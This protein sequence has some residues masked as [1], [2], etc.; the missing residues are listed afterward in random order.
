M[1][2]KDIYLDG[3]KI[4]EDSPTFLIAEVGVNHNGEIRIAKKLIDV[5]VKAQVDAVKF[6]TFITDKL[7]LK[8][9]PKVL[10]QKQSEGDKENFYEMIK[11]YEFTRDNF[12][13]LEEYCREKNIIFLS[14]PFDTIS[15]EWLEELNVPAFKVGSGDMNNYPL[16]KSIS[17]K[18]KPIL[19]STG[20]ATLIEVKE[21]VEFIKS[22]GNDSIVIF[23][24]TTNYPALD[25]ELNLNVLDTYKREFPDLF[26]GFS[27]HSVGLEASIG[28]VTKGAKFIEKHFTLDKSMVGPDHK[29]SL[30]P[31]E[32]VM[33]V[34]SIRKIE[35]ALG[36]YEKK[37]SVSEIEIAKIA[38]KSIV[39]KVDLKLGDIITENNI[40]TKR[41]GI[42][43][44]ASQYYKI[45]GKKVKTKAILKDTIIQMEDL[46]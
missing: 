3:R 4:S 39:S 40:T 45:M 19:L 7:I 5:A 41:P 35:E 32:L 36:S 10:Y 25:K 6:Q 37:P 43:I 42:G 26:L 27:D 30:D 46:E 20:M 28:A 8:D 14:T 11:K 24:C 34:K 44:P 31:D 21:S 13:I 2:V 22:E 9:T 38:R 1:P 15:I 12:K 33:W 17:L 18:K 29:A 23:Q 16:L